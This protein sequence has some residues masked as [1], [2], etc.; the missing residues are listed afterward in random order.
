MQGA[1][2]QQLAVVEAEAKVALNIVVQLVALVLAQVEAFLL[3][4]LLQGVNE[5]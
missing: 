4:E 5:S 3:P 1:D 2:P